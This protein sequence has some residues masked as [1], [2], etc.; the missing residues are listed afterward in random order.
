MGE[1]VP[2]VKYDPAKVPD[3]TLLY[4][5][6]G[7]ALAGLLFLWLSRRL[8]EPVR[9]LTRATEQV[10]AG[11]YDVEIPEPRGRDEIAL[12]SER[13]R[14]NGRPARGGGAAQALVPDV[15]VRQDSG[16]R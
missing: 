9:A 13:F 14:R 10:A 16:R 7:V 4:V 15:G 6:V 1:L 5:A 11:R 3:G 12:L 2:G 8:T